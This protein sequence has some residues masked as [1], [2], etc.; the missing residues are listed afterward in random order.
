MQTSA[1]KIIGKSGSIV[2][3]IRQK[4]KARV[5]NAQPAV[6][7]SLWAP[8]VVIGEWASIVSAY[9]A[10]SELVDGEIDD[11]VLEFTLNYRKKFFLYGKFLEPTIKFVSAKSNVRIF[12]PADFKPREQSFSE[13]EPM[14]LEGSFADVLNAVALLEHEAVLY[15]ERMRER[16]Q[17]EKKEKETKDKREE[18]RE[19]RKKDGK[20]KEK[21]AEGE[22]KPV[23]TILE[24]KSKGISG[25]PAEEKGSS[26]PAN[27][28]QEAS[29]KTAKSTS[30]DLSAKKD[31]GKPESKR[32]AKDGDAAKAG[33]VPSSSSAPTSS[34]AAA[35]TTAS[36]TEHGAKVTRPINIPYGI[37]GLL[38]AKKDKSKTSI[39]NQIQS[40][41]QT[42]ISK[43]LTGAG[44]NNAKDAA[45]EKRRR[46]V[47]DADQD[48]ESSS[49][50]DSDDSVASHGNDKADA[51]DQEPVVFNIVGFAAEHVEAAYGYLDR[52]VKGERIKT[53]LESIPRRPRNEGRSSKREGDGGRLGRG[54]K[55]ERSEDK[56]RSSGRRGGEDAK[57]PSAEGKAVDED[58]SKGAKKLAPAARGDNTRGGRSS[59]VPESSEQKDVEPRT[60]HSRAEALR[61]AANDVAK[62]KGGKAPGVGGRSEGRSTRG[63]RGGRGRGSGS[64]GDGKESAASEPAS[65]KA[66][67][68]DSDKGKS[69]GR[70][71]GKPRSGPP[72]RGPPASQS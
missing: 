60:Q 62:D 24:R 31:A 68:D 44:S 9:G 11:V 5:I 63:S 23:P 8:V 70:G 33:G 26:D 3:N 20:D 39:M 65:S 30:A 72:A 22:S 29:S 15:V 35:T 25:P 4:T 61:S 10:L 69:G 49:S 47:A 43:V 59:S 66:R 55:D 21:A 6:T 28:K 52:I 51:A 2:N 17:K 41:T 45:T 38:L 13:A 71:G 64:G 1:G 14:T 48:D 42:I 58:A 19:S 53:V 34:N 32:A 40:N 57:P 56:T 18:K 12:F 54:G 36:S 37:V 7:G 67:A 50:D 46:R 16:E 27:K